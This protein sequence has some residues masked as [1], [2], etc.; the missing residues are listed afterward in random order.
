[1]CGLMNSVRQLY[2]KNTQVCNLAKNGCEEKWPVNIV[3]RVSVD[4]KA[5]EGRVGVDVKHHVKL[6]FA[7]KKI[8]YSTETHP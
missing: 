1:M 4:E 2:W 3:I 5:G 7:L 6:I 8:H